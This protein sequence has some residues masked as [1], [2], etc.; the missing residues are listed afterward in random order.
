M[1]PDSPDNILFYYFY[2]PARYFFS[3]EREIGGR[4]G[5]GIYPAFSTRDVKKSSPLF[6]G[7]GVP[8]FFERLGMLSF[9]RGLIAYLVYSINSTSD[10]W[11][12]NIPTPLHPMPPLSP[13]LLLLPLPPS[14]CRLPWSHSLVFPPFLFDLNYFFNFPHAIAVAG[15]LARKTPAP[16]PIP[17]PCS[18]AVI[19]GRRST[20]PREPTGAL[21]TPAPPHPYSLPYRTTD[22]ALRLSPIAPVSGGSMRGAA[23]S[24]FFCLE[25]H[26]PLLAGFVLP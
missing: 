22:S 21:L 19:F 8:S 17:L 12:L 9:A 24:Y 1:F 5:K 7:S 14:L 4:E 3:L 26:F 15:D 20:Y 13:L 23:A 16:H 25:N 10:P 11:S 18:T 6:P 2:L